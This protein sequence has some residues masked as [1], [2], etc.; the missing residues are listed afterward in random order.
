MILRSFTWLSCLALALAP[1]SAEL[2]AQASGG[3][4]RMVARTGATCHASPDAASPVSHR[5]RITDVVRTTK[6]QRG[7][8]RTWYFDFSRSNGSSPC[9][10]DGALTVPFNGTEDVAYA[11]VVDAALATRGITFD[12][13]AELIVLL[14]MRDPSSSQKPLVERYPLLAY[15]RLVLVDTAATMVQRAPYPYNLV[16][17]AAH[18]QLLGYNEPQGMYHVPGTRFRALVEANS[19]TAWADDAAWT[20]ATRDLGGDECS[21]SCYLDYIM[22]GPAEYWTRFSSGR[23]ITEALAMGEGLMRGAFATMSEG[24]PS[25]AEIDDV[26][27]SLAKVATPARKKLLQSLDSLERLIKPD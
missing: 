4:R 26:R 1:A 10:I 12:A 9:W 23:H 8:G 19:R 25:K 14:E 20:S 27:R 3:E 11:A 16:W 6:Q 22:R 2:G 21:P 13:L 15:K 17:I 24:P 7:S 18:Q 5:Y